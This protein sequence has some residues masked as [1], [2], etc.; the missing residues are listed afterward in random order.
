[1]T[2]DL[3]EFVLFS[4]LVIAN[5]TTTRAELELPYLPSS[6]R[7]RFEQ[8]DRTIR[9][10]NFNLPHFRGNQQE[11]CDVSDDDDNIPASIQ[12]AATS[13]IIIS[14]SRQRPQSILL[15]VWQVKIRS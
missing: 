11:T 14:L 10:K 6:L 13:E 4:P 12:G 1:M 3:V 7:E 2:F 9:Q 15:Q 5:N 8:T